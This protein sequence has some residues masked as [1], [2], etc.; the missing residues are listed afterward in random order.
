MQRVLV[1]HPAV[2]NFIRKWQLD[3]HLT[4]YLLAIVVGALGGYGAV[5]FRFLIKAAQYL[6]Y[7]NSEEFLTFFQTVP[8]YLKLLL[9]VVGGLAAGLLIRWGGEKA[10]GHGVPELIEAVVLRGGRISWRTAAARIS[11][12]AITIGSG[13]SVGREGPII[14]LGSFL[15][16][17]VA[18]LLRQARDR[19]RILMSCGAAAGI[20]ATFHAPITG[21]LFAVELLLGDFALASFSPVVLASVTAATV[22]G[23]HLGKLPAF[24]V[25][26]FQVQSLWEYAVY[27]VL[28][29]ISGLVAVVFINCLYFCQ[30]R[31]ES[32][33]IPA[34]LKPGLGGLL[35]GAMLLLAPQVFGV[36]YGA[37]N[38]ALL[39]QMDLVLM[40]SLLFAKILA[41]SMS[42]GSGAA[43][44]ILAPSLFIGAMTGGSF[45][46]FA[47]YWLP[48]PV[49]SASSYALIGM[50]AVV[51]GCTQA[52]VTAIL[53]TFE[54]CNQSQIIIP[55]LAAAI[56]STITASLLK[57][58]SIYSLKLLRRG[59]DVSGGR[60]QN[61]LR[62]IR[63]GEV[64]VRDIQSVVESAPMAV[65][66]DLFNKFDLSC[67]TVV[68]S[69]GQLVGV[70]SFHD[71]SGLA[72]A[73]EMQQLL[74]ARDLVNPEV[75]RL[76]PTD[77]LKTALDKLEREKAAQLPVVS[78]DGTNKLVGLVQERDVLAAYERE[79][80]LRWQDLG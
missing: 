74:I 22:S 12:S 76:F 42:L 33:K 52:P 35:L 50:G 68:N 54:L 70:I 55:V 79:L 49:S 11:A 37:I 59:I 4:L 80:E 63:V 27:P 61:I 66:L 36:G 1:V 8:F 39:N 45:A 20:S 41:T 29:C 62:T 40:A 73:E 14:H 28:G 57:H 51:A 72:A 26:V 75:A 47:A 32:L 64:M 71:I 5:F 24:V 18:Q 65:V 3:E 21:M 46:Y 56:V 53:L 78:E 77:S 19:E 23:L 60:E 7:Q 43:G 34:W 31:F 17:A 30:D 67:L 48:F 38:L 2:K 58:G 25:P 9:P 15:G 44:G 69:K 16:S 6:F 13:G 10:R